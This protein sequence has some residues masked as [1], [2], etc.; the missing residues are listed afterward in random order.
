MSHLPLF[1]H[2]DMISAPITNRRKPHPNQRV[3]ELDFQRGYARYTRQKYL[4]TPR[5]ASR[6]AI[7]AF[8]DVARKLSKELGELYVVDHIVP[9]NGGIV[10]GLHVPWNLQVIRWRSNANKGNRHW[11]DMPGETR[12]LL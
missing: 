1:P 6:A 3:L 8:Y 10:S 11:P 7:K 5:W 9:L 4:H 2:L 12:S